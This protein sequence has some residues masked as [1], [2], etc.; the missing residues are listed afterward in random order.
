MT[1]IQNRIKQKKTKNMA[2]TFSAEKPSVIKVVGGIALSLGV[3][4]ATVWVISK[5][6][7]KGQ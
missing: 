7:K 1:K 3:I 2:D 5:A 4:F 6:W